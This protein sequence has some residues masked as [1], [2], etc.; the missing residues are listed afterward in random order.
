MSRGSVRLIVAVAVAVVG[1]LFGVT[2]AVAGSVDNGQPV[3]CT[4]AVQGGNGWQIGDSGRVKVKSVPVG[5]TLC[6]GVQ[7]LSDE[8]LEVLV[9][10]SVAPAQSASDVVNGAS[11]VFPVS[12]GECGEFTVFTRLMDEQDA[13]Y[14]PEWSWSGCPTDSS[15]DISDD[16]VTEPDNGGISTIPGS[17]EPDVGDDWMPDPGQT[18]DSTPLDG[19]TAAAATESTPISE[20]EVPVVDTELRELAETGFP[21]WVGVVAAVC[22]ILAGVG[23]VILATRRGGDRR[24]RHAR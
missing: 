9:A 2:P 14:R 24:A 5:W 21:T 18:V 3:D 15:N 13:D 19:E 6:V 8:S 10:S 20:S 23:I 12:F 16:A 17:G 11:L 1:A 4:V 22:S 7:V